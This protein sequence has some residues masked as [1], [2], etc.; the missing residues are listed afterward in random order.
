MIGASAVCSGTLAADGDSKAPA[1]IAT[2]HENEQ[3]EGRSFAWSLAERA[4]KD[5]QC[6][7]VWSFGK[8]AIL[9]VESGEEIV[10]KKYFLT[11]LDNEPM[12]ALKLTGLTTNGAPDCMGNRA[13]EV[14]GERTLYLQFLNDGS[15]FT[16]GS[17]D[18]LSC[19][20]VASARR[21]PAH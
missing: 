8:D 11:A 4:A 9:M 17:T 1:L 7:E 5:A 16:C 19:Y 10:T 13:T 12:M 2:A 20:G 18:G 14:G 3:L 21:D 15:F 6:R